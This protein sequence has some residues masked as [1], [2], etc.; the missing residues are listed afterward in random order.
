MLCY[1]HVFVLSFKVSQYLYLED[2]NIKYA[3]L[4]AEY[5]KKH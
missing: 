1:Y 2:E 4:K 5:L 3:R